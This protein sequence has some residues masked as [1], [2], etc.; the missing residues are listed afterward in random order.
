VT[1]PS[2]RVVVNDASCLIDLRKGRLLRALMSLPYRFVIPLPVRA[3][4]ID[5]TDD[6][7]SVLDDGGLETFDLPPDR[8][9]EAFAVKSAYPRLSAND[10]FCLVAARCWSDSILLT[11][12]N[13]L[14]RVAAGEGARVHGVLWV[15]DELDAHAACSADLLVAALEA[16]RG[17]QAV[18]LPS[19][20]LA[21]R[22]SRLRP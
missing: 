18:F 21:E 8:V 3:E 5:F 15:I 4:L 19:N 16:W 14:R 13:L 22:L 1:P 10:C 7:W 12:D 11:G 2:R 17:D 6:D 20:A 9:G